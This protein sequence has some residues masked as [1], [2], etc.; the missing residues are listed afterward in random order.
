MPIPCARCRTE[1]EPADSVGS[2]FQLCQDCWERDSSRMWWSVIAALAP[3]EDTDL[4]TE[5]DLP[6]G[7]PSQIT[8]SHCGQLKAP[9]EFNRERRRPS[10]RRSDCRDCQREYNSRFRKQKP[11]YNIWNL[12]FQR[13]YN[14]GNPGYRFYGARGIRVC[15]RWH[16]YEA[17]VADMSPRPSPKHSIDRIDGNGDYSPEN[18]RWALQQEQTLNLRSNRNIEIDGI[19]RPLAEWARLNGIPKPTVEARL[20]RYGWDAKAAVTTPVRAW[21]GKA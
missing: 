1:F 7:E 17:F 20:Y 18:C 14:E 5:H 8:C 2:D 13:C 15:Q 21:G 4:M 11:L 3:P 16:E 9:S 19:I 6:N 10:G 12:M